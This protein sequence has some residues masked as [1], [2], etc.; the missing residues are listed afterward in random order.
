MSKNTDTF[1][2]LAE[3]LALTGKHPTLREGAMICNL[4]G[5]TNTSNENYNPDYPEGF[6]KAWSEAM[7]DFDYSKNPN[8]KKIAKMMKD[9]FV[10]ENGE[11]VWK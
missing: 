2:K 5:I 7:K 4:C 9:T 11:Y 8:D 1:A 6:A 3:L 10:G